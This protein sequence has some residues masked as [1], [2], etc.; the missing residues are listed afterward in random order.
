MDNGEGGKVNVTLSEKQRTTIGFLSL[1]LIGVGNLAQKLVRG[2][3][4][5]MQDILIIIT[6][7]LP[8]AGRFAGKK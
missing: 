2:E 8:S 1:I 3:P 5:D 7:I 6:S 4:I